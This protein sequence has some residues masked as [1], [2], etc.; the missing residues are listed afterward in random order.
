MYT[1]W[2]Y[3]I[4]YDF[5]DTGNKGI[6]DAYL[7]YNGFDN[8][9][10]KLGNFKDPFSLQEQTSSKFVTFTERSLTTAFAA[11]RHIGFMGTTA[12]QHWTLA[13]GLFGDT[14]S[15][16]GGTDDEDWGWG[17]RATWAPISEK[18]QVVHVGLGLNYRDTDTA[19][20]SQFKT[21]AE[22]HV[23][24]VSI[25]DTGTI[26]DTKDYFKVG[27]E[28]AYVK[29]PFSTQAEY[30]R[31]D[32]SREGATDLEFD[33]WY[34]Q[35]G[36]FFTGESR[37]YSKGKFG[38]ITPK[39]SVGAGGMGAWELALRYSTIDLSDADIDGGEADTF[40]L[41][42]NWFAT[43]TLRFSA[44]YVDVLDVKGGTYDDAE[45]SVFQVRSQWAF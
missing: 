10:L 11:G 3:K 4:Q 31:T 19:G 6:K 22:T 7:S 1:D 36:Y 40:T 29:G 33:G 23:S 43:P 45:P 9:S 37:N 34:A 18:S 17:A 16:K 24:G 26:A 28:L 38:K 8:L 14:V 30:I 42:L 32:V 20:S 12:H 27:A 13:A 41:G 21:A 35:A 44:N 25:V 5:V 2:G 39:S 15:T